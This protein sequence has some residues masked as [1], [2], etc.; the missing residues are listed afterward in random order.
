MYKHKENFIHAESI[1]SVGSKS[2]VFIFFFFFFFSSLYPFICDAKK[3]DQN[4]SEEYLKNSE[5]EEDERRKENTSVRYYKS[6]ISVLAV[7]Q[8]VI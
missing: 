8:T 5:Y 1:K 6:F 3:V 7:K 2:K 4:G